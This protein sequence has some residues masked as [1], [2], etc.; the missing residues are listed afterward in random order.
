MKEIC[1]VCGLEGGA[2]IVCPG[3]GHKYPSTPEDNIETVSQEDTVDEEL[4]DQDL[5]DSLSPDQIENLASAEEEN[6]DLLEVIDNEEVLSDEVVVDEKREED[7]DITLESESELNMQENNSV[8]KDELIDILEEKITEV[9]N[10]F[11]HK[12]AYD[13]TKDKQIDRLHD[14]LQHYKRDLIAKTNRPLVNGMI[15]MF[16]DSDKLIGNLRKK[17]V[18]ELTPER[19][20]K[21][22]EGVK[23]DIEIMLDQNGIV[24][25]TESSDDFIPSRQQ[26]IRKIPTSD[27]R[28]AGNIAERIRPGFEQGSDLIKKERVAVYVYDESLVAGE[29]GEEVRQ[30]KDDY[31]TD[32]KHNS[33]IGDKNE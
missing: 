15:K 24:V 1:P 25:F 2:N 10:A 13:T 7:A 32:S 11:E 23:E 19:F 21:E 18:E 20:F 8:S 31:P 6:S 17:S 30:Y 14:E 22:L 33:E 29:K 16:D 27:K 26:V 4:N 12:L 3:C 9:L 5:K 28:L